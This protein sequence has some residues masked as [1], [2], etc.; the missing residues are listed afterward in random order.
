MQFETFVK[1]VNE[2]VPVRPKMYVPRYYDFKYDEF[3]ISGEEL[4]EL[5]L[6]DYREAGGVS[7]GSCWDTSSPQ[8]YSSNEPFKEWLDI[9]LMKYAPD[10]T[11]LEYKEIGRNS[12][13]REE[14]EYE[15]YGNYTNYEIKEM[16]LK[17]LYEY[18]LSKGFLNHGD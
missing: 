9:I 3:D 10:L 18:L 17:W 15:Y 6:F 4:D 13:I 14:T 2:L 5:V 1:E 16:S 12:R 7:G 8:P 11:F